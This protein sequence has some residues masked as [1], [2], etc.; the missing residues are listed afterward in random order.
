MP[1][2]FT[3][4]TDE[5]RAFREEVRDWLAAALPDRLRGLSTRPPFDD[6]YPPVP[7]AP[8]DALEEGARELS[9]V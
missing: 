5:D 2:S 4:D 8:L 9:L 6:A 7:E 3:T 1:I